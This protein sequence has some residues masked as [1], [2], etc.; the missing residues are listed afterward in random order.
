M[1][2]IENDTG[3]EQ[4][5]IDLAK[6][7]ELWGGEA[8]MIAGWRT[9]LYDRPTGNSAG[10]TDRYFYDT[11][12]KKF[13]SRAEIARALGLS[14]APAVRI[15]GE[16]MS[17]AL[18]PGEKPATF[19]FRWDDGSEEEGTLK[20]RG[21][22][23][24]F[25]GSSKAFEIGGDFREFDARNV[26]GDT[27][28]CRPAR[29]PR[30]WRPILENFYVLPATRE[31]S[32]PSHEWPRCN[33]AYDAETGTSGCGE[34]SDCVNRDLYV[35][36][37]LD[38]CGGGEP[39]DAEPETCVECAPARAAR[40]STRQRRTDGRRKPC[41]NTVIQR[42]AFPPMEI[43]DTGDDNRGFGLRCRVDV[44]AGTMLG[45]YRGD[46]IDAAELQ[47]R[48]ETRDAA[49]PFYIAALGDGLA[50]DAGRKGA[51]ARFA[52]HSCAPNCALEKWRV[53]E[54]PRL[55]LVARGAI[56]ANTELTYDY[57]AGGGVADVTVAQQCRCGAPNCAGA[58]G[59]KVD[60]DQL[61][62]PRGYVEDD[63]DAESDDDDGALRPAATP[64]GQVEGGCRSW[65]DDEVD[66]LKEA[67]A[68][69]GTRDWEGV[70]ADYFEHTGRTKSQLVSKWANVKKRDA[71]A[72]AAA[73]AANDRLAGGAKKRK[74]K[75]GEPAPPKKKKKP[76][77]AARPL[78]GGRAAGR[79]VGAAARAA[80]AGLQLAEALFAAATRA[81][82]RA[83][84]KD[85]HCF[86]RLP[87][88]CAMPDA[89][90]EPMDGDAALVNCD[91]CECWVHPRCVRLA[92]L[93]DDDAPFFCA[94]CCLERGDDAPFRRIG[95]EPGR[96]WKT[97]APAATAETV[98]AAL[99][100]FEA[101]GKA[102]A[103]QYAR[104]A[105]DFVAKVGAE[106]ERWAGR[107]D[108]ALASSAKPKALAELVCEGQTLEVV[109]EPRM[110]KA[111]A[112]L[113]ASLERAAAADVSTSAESP[114]SS[115][116]P[117]DAPAAEAPPDAMTDTLG[118]P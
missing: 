7:V 116:T 27:K 83:G 29:V 105:R 37:A 60:K 69:R 63:P 30:R 75:P 25:L 84:T 49:D 66:A 40:A 112:A 79:F 51:Y 4:A 19:Q 6:A 106:A 47:R 36:C 56:P 53:G 117:A 104:L 76:A 109:D 102:D 118:P 17:G 54:E 16:G 10:T 34:C 99:A 101:S 48:K 110:A 50:I 100:A 98:A 68:A 31:P 85:L 12:G 15:K 111:K 23:R 88:D 61:V 94:T 89:E 78:G 77:R 67:V 74:A 86:C 114:S 22:T 59:A 33:C 62:V 42:R 58:I 26:L 41:G 3:Y 96:V 103:L 24:D 52:N 39:L 57:N 80:D 91:G 45:E 92:A 115:T 32:G 97:W 113:L 46:V 1:P 21:L 11:S 72:A 28:V 95:E 18:Q 55:V 90:G 93:P 65:T 5:M 87:E 108:A 14:G 81:D 20:S 43:F 38:C 2:L 8:S 44:K 73:D 9:E 64:M 71:A 82:E 13:R 107:C 70:L 35:E